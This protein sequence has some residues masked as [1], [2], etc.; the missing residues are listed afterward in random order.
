MKPGF[1]KDRHAPSRR[2]NRPARSATHPLFPSRVSNRLL[3]EETLRFQNALRQTDSAPAPRRI[4]PKGLGS[5]RGSG[6][7][8]TTPTSR[9]SLA[10]SAIGLNFACDVWGAGKSTRG[11]GEQGY[12]SPKRPCDFCRMRVC[13]YAL[14]LRSCLL[15]TYRPGA[16]DFPDLLFSSRMSCLLHPQAFLLPPLH[17]PLNADPIQRAGRSRCAAGRRLHTDSP[18]ESY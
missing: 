15:D 12:P 14:V 13:A 11:S 18:S 6:I 4:R 10:S 2:W 16:E 1:G 8:H 17:P 5:N 9:L 7:Q 3:R